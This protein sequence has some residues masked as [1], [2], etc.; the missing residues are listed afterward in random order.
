MHDSNVN[1]TPEPSVYTGPVDPD[2]SYDVVDGEGNLVEKAVEVPVNPFI[3]KKQL[4][5]HLPRVIACKHRLDLSRPPRYRNCDSCWFAFF[6]NNPR[7]VE[8]ADELHQAGN[9]RLIEQ[10]QGTKF[11]EKFRNFMSTVAKLKEQGLVVG[12]EGAQV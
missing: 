2:R 6:Q 10:L 7:T 1:N 12:Q 11:L 4:P 3:R 9:S 5:C 8:T